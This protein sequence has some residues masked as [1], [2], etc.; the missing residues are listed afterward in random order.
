M[1]VDTG[2]SISIISSD[3]LEAYN[4]KDKMG[5]LQ[6]PINL[7]S[8]NGE[9][10]PVRGECPLKLS[11]GD[12]NITH[13]V[14]VADILNKFILG[15]DFMS[16]HKC[17]ILISKEKM[18]INETEVPY[19]KHEN[20][21]IPT[22]RVILDEELDIPPNSEF[23]AQGKVENP[24]FHGLVAII[25]PTDKFI[26]KYELLIP[27]TLVRVNGD[28]VPIRYMNLND[29][30]VKLHKGTI[31]ATIERVHDIY[32]TT[33]PASNLCT[34][35]MVAETPLPAHLDQV[36]QKL[37]ESITTDQK[38]K[39]ENLLKEF[40]S[41]FSQGPSDMGLTDLVEHKIDTGQSHPIKQHPRRIPL[42][43]MKEAQ[44]EIESML[45]KGVIETSDSPWSSPVVLVKK[46]DGSIRFCIDYRKLNDITIKDSYPVP[47]IDTTLDAM[48]GSRW[49]STIDLKSGYWQVK[50]APEDR[51]KT[52]FSIPGGGHWQFL[53]MPF[54]LCNAG[55][56]FERLMEKVL[57][58]LSWKICLVY[59]DDIIILSK[60]FDKHIENL[61]EVFLRLEKANLKMNPKKCTFLQK[62]VTFLGHIVNENGIATDPSK[63]HAVKTWPVPQN[64]KDV[65][66]FLGL[67]SYYRRFVHK[68][69]D[70]ARPLHKLTEANKK[71][72]WGEDCQ[73]AFDK[74]KRA[75]TS[76]D[77]LSYPSDEGQFIL[78]TDAS[79]FGLG[80][81]LS[82]EQ[83]GEIKVISFF[84][85][86]FSATERRYCVTR[87]ELLAIIKSVKH[88]HHYLYGKTFKVR[89]DHGSLT[90]LLNFK[91][92][93]GQLA[94]WLELLSSYDFKI[95][96]R[97]GRSHNNADALSRRPCL[98]LP[99]K[100]CGNAEAKYMAENIESVHSIQNH[101][102]PENCCVTTRSGQLEGSKIQPS[103]DSTKHKVELSKTCSSES[104]KY[105]VLYL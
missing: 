82:Q 89:T 99:C 94:R 66:S 35:N 67:C 91:N 13:N 95:E 24:V 28:K 57:S 23:I 43:K 8:A 100:H 12:T 83:N 69:A 98:D 47:R 102:S 2:A 4:L 63:T 26:D 48:S 53:S 31:L 58:N 90:W 10:I 6:S 18:R 36:I 105:A 71:F 70:I 27:K 84:S 76:S 68:F 96:Y 49:F 22:C 32:K 52:A 97:A 33:K 64:I 104:L 79:N 7:T 74:L 39:L 15:M 38:Q 93:E 86:T 54:G 92:P 19:S 44:N 11:V 34:I 65:R 45:E 80:A 25:E 55:A 72:V 103:L 61:R 3:I 37:P 62:E 101:S 21:D 17:D 29:E 51:P 50:M 46:K 56:T 14:V 85:K 81:V 88:F 87:R 73:Q 1:L 59:L 78:D 20:M 5:L 40:Q 16:Q 30:S 41:S 75:L 9:R 77:V 42:A 60:T